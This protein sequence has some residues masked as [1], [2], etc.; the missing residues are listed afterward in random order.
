MKKTYD[1]YI[2]CTR[3]LDDRGE[4]HNE[5]D[6]AMIY[7]NGTLKWYIHGNAHRL[8]GPAIVWSD[9]SSNWYFNGFHMY[10]SFY[11]W[12]GNMEID[13]LKPTEYEAILI[14]MTWG[15][16]GPNHPKFGQ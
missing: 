4:P 13:P 1:R 16:Y 6:P 2:G 3:Y 15:S 7:D 10:D 11:R 5:N 14:A 8:D 9:G 12:L